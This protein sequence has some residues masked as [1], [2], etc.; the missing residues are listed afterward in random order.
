PAPPRSGPSTL[1]LHDALPISGRSRIVVGLLDL[2]SVAFFM[3]FA[4]KPM[5]LFGL[6]GLVLAGLGVLVGLVTIVLRVQH[7]MLPSGFRPL[8]YLVILLATLGFL[9]FGLGFLAALTA[10]QRTELDALRRRL[11]A[12]GSRRTK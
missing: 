3:F 10:P 5:M 12:Q 1:S 11:A 6:T 4:R 9:L 7:A 2:I 8:L